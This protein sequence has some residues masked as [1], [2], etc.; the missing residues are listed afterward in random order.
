M[1]G[2]SPP[3]RAAEADSASVGAKA[4]SCHTVS[5]LLVKYHCR[6]FFA[7]LFIIIGMTAIAGFVDGGIKLSDQNSNDF[8]VNDAKP[9][10][11][12]DGLNNAKLRVDSVEATKKQILPRDTANNQRGSLNIMFSSKDGDDIFTPGN[13][14]EICDTEKLFFDHPEYE[15]YCVLEYSANGTKVGCKTP[16][17]SL[18]HLFY[19]ASFTTCT[20]TSDCNTKNAQTGGLGIVAQDGSGNSH[21]VNSLS[22][23]RATFTFDKCDTLP[24]WK[25][26]AVR[27]WMYFVVKKKSIAMPGV[28]LTGE[29]LL[30]FYLDVDT[31]TSSPTKSTRTRSML[32]IGK[33]LDGFS[34]DT[35]RQDEQKGLY[36]KYYGTLEKSF[37]KKFGL[38][39]KFLRSAY[40]TKSELKGMD[41][42][43]FAI[44]MMSNEF[45]RM[46]GEDFL[47][48]IGS[49]VIVLCWILLH[50]GS[51]FVGSL[52][53]LQIL[54]S[55]PFAYTIY[56]FIF[57]IRA[58]SQMHILAIFL[59]LGVG[60]DDIFVLTDAWHQSKRDVKQKPGATVEEQLTRRMT[61][62][63]SRTAVAV[64]NT[65]FTTAMAFV[66]TGISP[67][68]SIST[69]GWFATIAIAVN[70][71]FVVSFTPTAIL[72]S[73]LYVNP[74]CSKLWNPCKKKKEE[75][76]EGGGG[77]GEQKRPKPLVQ[78]FF[79]QLYVP[80]MLKR[81]SPGS[82]VKPVAIF[83][84]ALFGGYAIQGI[85]FTAQLTPPT[86]AEQ[87]FPLD[88]M[89]TGLTDRMSDNYLGGSDDGYLT[90]SWVFG[91]TGLDREADNYDMYN[92]DE[93]RGIAKFDNDF[94]IYPEANQDA[95]LKMCD[96]IE[97]LQC[98]DESKTGEFLEA[99][100]D[101]TLHRLARSGTL[102]CFM[103]EF[104][105]WHFYRHGLVYPTSANG[106]T[107]SQFL[108]RLKTFRKTTTPGNETTKSWK[109]T[110]GFID[111]Q[112][113]FVRI[114]FTSTMVRLKPVLLKEP[115]YE[116]LEKIVEEKKE[117]LPEGLK[118]LFQEGGYYG[119]VWM[120]TQR[121]LVTS[122]MTGM[123][124]CFPI[125]LGVLLIATGNVLVSIYATV[126]IGCIVC[127]VLGFTR[128]FMNWDL[129]IAE[130]IAGIIVIGFSVDYVVHLAHMYMDGLHAG[131]FSGREERFQYAATKM[132]GTIFAGAM[133]TAGSG[134]VMWACQMTFFTKMAV[135]IC[136]T[137]F[138]SLG[139]SLFFFLPLC[140]LIGPSGKTADIP[141]L[142]HGPKSTAAAAVIPKA[143]GAEEEE[144][145]APDFTLPAD[146]N[147]PKEESDNVEEETV[148]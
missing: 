45:Q 141:C 78:K 2:D 15:D 25:V 8:T 119:W 86:K 24:T 26:N 131:G 39:W 7:F 70:Y 120:I 130:S 36:T 128:L 121:Q 74:F 4:Q 87:W 106:V 55:L 108:D 67:M 37:F 60:A 38:E 112:L 14:K 126:S 140:V 114:P 59:V 89:M 3:D 56:R 145:P 138:F 73:E 116:Y 147:L 105:N 10:L 132:G 53:M 34:S 6:F 75:N 136:M 92:P 80:T 69:F 63:Y 64:F 31:L 79:E 144:K 62:A 82:S 134:A 90:M 135:L 122:M 72:L 44:S 71:L 17:L 146:Y 137:I 54:L 49:I 115:L 47:A 102:V 113:K 91:I 107:K 1:A 12:L 109:T 40:R 84:V 28:T 88:H 96:F 77:S 21:V 110:I 57:G 30:G 103:K 16:T 20:G 85:Y 23:L 48:P 117:D 100:A 42:E 33:P 27:D 81:A 32:T 18:A 98:K 142:H 51:G 41:V 46:L 97:T 104:R 58:F 93:N 29:Q 50:T 123:A 22:M 9:T 148:V 83:F 124:I 52:G 76:V 68:M 139:Y 129:G 43:W 133:T 11:E 19:A 94:D 143:D 95:L 5:R 127:S 35:D 125:A 118:Y 101:Q 111:G 66:S 99:C 61:Y 13:L 65:S